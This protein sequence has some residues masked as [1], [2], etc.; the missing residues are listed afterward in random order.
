M[1]LLFSFENLF[2]SSVAVLATPFD[3]SLISQFQSLV[4]FAI[5]GKIA[6]HPNKI[7]YY[8]QSL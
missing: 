6:M 2:I 1:E 5:S 3:N 7:P 8:I 4:T